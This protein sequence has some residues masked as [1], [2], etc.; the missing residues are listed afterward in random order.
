[1]SPSGRI[2]RSTTLDLLDEHAQTLGALDRE[3]HVG[4]LLAVAPAGHPSAHARIRSQGLHQGE[5]S[6]GRWLGD[7]V[8][9]RVNCQSSSST[10]SGKAGAPDP[11]TSRIDR[12]TPAPE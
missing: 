11:V 7:V 12:A 4:R 3:V 1:M 9:R 5:E 6:A 2:R 10:S 8:G